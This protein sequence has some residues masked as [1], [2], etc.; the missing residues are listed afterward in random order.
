MKSASTWSLVP[1]RPLAHGLFTLALAAVASLGGVACGDQGDSDTAGGEPDEA[2]IM[3]GARDSAHPAAGL[4]MAGEP[5]A[6]DSSPPTCGGTL[7]A[8][9]VVLTA[10]HCMGQ[11][12]SAFYL[13]Q[14]VPITIFD[15]RTKALK[16]M[17]RFAVREV[18]VFPSF[19]V[20]RAFRPDGSID[21]GYVC[22]RE[23]IDVAL[24]RLD[25]PVTDVTP[26]P[27]G[28]A[29]SVG[30]ACEVVGY[31]THKDPARDFE[32][33]HERRVAHR[34][35]REAAPYRLFSDSLDGATRQGDSG[36]G[37]FCDG[38]IVGVLSCTPKWNPSASATYDDH[39]RFDVIRGWVDFHIGRWK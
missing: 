27:L 34:R 11:T 25:K 32:T 36:G 18:M 10:A 17:R 4:L 16:A 15:E 35:V 14:G 12:L 5:K 19:E 28:D 8:P 30:A 23:I 33:T 21:S 31:S 37:L 9:N 38:R 2:A 39:A 3:G 26:V 20:A 1:T 29:P 6:G 24:V 7:V 13:G 22:G